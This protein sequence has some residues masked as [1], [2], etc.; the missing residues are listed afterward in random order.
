MKDNIYLKFQEIYNQKVF[1]KIDWND[2]ETF[3]HYYSTS[4]SNLKVVSKLFLNTIGKRVF[5]SD[6][7]VEKAELFL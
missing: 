4:L 2:C 3:L 5:Q 7:L 1:E 6:V